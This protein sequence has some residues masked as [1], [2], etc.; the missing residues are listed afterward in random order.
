MERDSSDF[1]PKELENGVAGDTKGW[2]VCLEALERTGSP[3]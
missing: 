3:V 2:E 1:R